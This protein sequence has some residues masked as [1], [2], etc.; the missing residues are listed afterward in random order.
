[1]NSFNPPLEPQSLKTLLALEQELASDSPATRMQALYKLIMQGEALREAAHGDRFTIPPSPAQPELLEVSCRISSRLAEVITRKLDDLTERFSDE[2]RI[3]SARALGT[4][5]QPS[6][7]VIQ[8]LCTSL[9]RDPFWGVVVQSAT[10]LVKIC[11]IS[12]SNDLLA[13]SGLLSELLPTYYESIQTKD[14]SA[15]RF[16]KLS[17]RVFKSA[18]HGKYCPDPAAPFEKR[19]QDL[20]QLIKHEFDPRNLKAGSPLESHQSANKIRALVSAM[21]NLIKNSAC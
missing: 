21:A 19:F 13:S 17:D 1:M 12:A 20:C 7:A 10:A 8:N 2:E 4:F 9:C 14:G 18:F 16:L 3:A 6:Y 11:E 15:G 5:G